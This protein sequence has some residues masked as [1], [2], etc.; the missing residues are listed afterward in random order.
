M[1]RFVLIAGLILIAAAF[2]AAQD[3]KGKARV[4]GYVTDEQGK[5]IEGV[6]VKLFSL[7]ANQGFEVRTDK[8]GKWV[9]AW[10]R[11]GD[12]NVDLDKIG[13]EPK[14]GVINLNENKKNPDIVLVMK[15]VEGLIITDDVK[16]MLAKGNDLYDQ[17]K[18]DEALAVY[19]DILA[20]FPDLYPMYR[21]I[22]NCYFAQEKYDLA[23][24]N[25]LKVLEKDPKN[26]QAIL[27]IGNCYINRGDAAK[28]MEW[29]AKIEFE[30][31]EDPVVLYNLGT[32]YYN[33]GKYEDALKCYLKAVEK[34]PDSVDGLYQLGLTYIN[35]S[36]KAEAIA[37]FESCLK[38]LPAD[39]PKA[40]QVKGFL[41]YLRK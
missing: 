5:P 24:Q 36:K 25:F 4:T 16:E 37:S 41:D 6:R 3:Y 34:Q 21:S 10:V 20:K 23:E 11:G 31:I 2:V 18:Y 40:A 29:Y 22:G 8:D 39:S 12:W 26:V 38:L 7:K 14:K 9:A 15:R 35:L 27:M 30:K 28:A 17:K 1:K 19:Q 32:T 13:F 33:S